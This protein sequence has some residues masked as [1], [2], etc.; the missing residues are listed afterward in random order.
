MNYLINQINF[1][2]QNYTIHWMDCK[3]KIKEPK[4][5]AKNRKTTPNYMYVY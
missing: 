2:Y 3:Q 1:L 5:R 4:K